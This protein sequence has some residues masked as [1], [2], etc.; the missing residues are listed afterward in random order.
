MTIAICH[1]VDFGQYKIKTMT[2][3]VGHRIDFGQYE[4]KKNE[5]QMA[6]TVILV[7]KWSHG[8]VFSRQLNTLRR[9]PYLKEYKIQFPPR[10]HLVE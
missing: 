6:N 9:V 2:K 3:I 5:K 8:I 4:I 1:H 10:I 7:A